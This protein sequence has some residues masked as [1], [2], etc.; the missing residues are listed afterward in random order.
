[1]TRFVESRE[2]L[3]TGQVATICD[4]SAQTVINWLDCGRFTFTRLGRGPRRIPAVEVADFLQKNN[5][6]MPEW[7]Q[8]F[9]PAHA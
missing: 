3:T 1:M 6:P 9:I 4:V 2:R 7:L 5:H 8:K